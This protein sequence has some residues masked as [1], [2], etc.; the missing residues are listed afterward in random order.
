[1]KSALAKANLSASDMDYCEINEAFAVVAM[2]NARNLGIPFD[3]V[4]V[5]GGAC[6]LGH[7]L[8]AS[9]ARIIG[10]LMSVLKNKDASMGIAAICNGGGAATSIIIERLN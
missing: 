3:R 7:P 1:M 6:A 9:G 10:T 2:V 8:G 4:N 5:Q